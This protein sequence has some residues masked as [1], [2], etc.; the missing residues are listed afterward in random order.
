METHSQINSEK[1]VLYGK[2]H[3]FLVPDIHREKG[4][5]C[6]DCHI[7]DEMKPDAEPENLQSG[8]QIR[9]TDCHGT[10]GTLPEEYLLIESDPNTKK[11]LAR[12]NLNP[13]LKKKVK[14]GETVLVNSSG[15]AMLHIKKIKN[16]WALYSKVTGK[17]HIIPL[18]KNLKP[19]IA[20]QIP[21]HMKEIE[22][23]SYTHQTL[24]TTPYV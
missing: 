8:T 14:A 7:G 12:N 18:L 19:S 24:P 3:E 2:E 21:K 4:M 23:V 10:H 11:M 5:H 22:S 1:P 16:D 6:I 13:N 9:C 20:H 17:K 15:S